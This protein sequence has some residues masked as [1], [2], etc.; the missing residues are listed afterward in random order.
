MKHNWIRYGWLVLALAACLCF[1]AVCAAEEVPAG[2]ADLVPDTPATAV[3]TGGQLTWFRFVPGET[4]NYS[5][6]SSTD[7][8]TFAYLYEKTGDVLHELKNDDDG[9]SRN[10]FQIVYELTAGKEYYFGVRFY[11]GDKSGSF[12]VTIEKYNGLVAAMVNES[13]NLTEEIGKTVTLGISASSGKG[14]VTFTWA[15]LNEDGMWVLAEGKTGPEITVSV[16]AGQTHYQCKVTDGISTQ[17][18][19]F[20]V[21]GKDALTASAKGGETS[22]RVTPGSSREMEVEASSESG[23]INYEWYKGWNDPDGYSHHEA[24]PGADSAS[25]TAE[26][27]SRDCY[28]CCEVRSTADSA[29]VYFYFYID[30][31]ISVEP[32][33]KSITVA[34][35]GSAEMSVTAETEYGPLSYQW[36]YYDDDHSAA[37]VEG[38]TGA[39]FTAQNIRHPGVYYCQVENAYGQSQ[40]AY[41]YISVEGDFDAYPESYEIYT[42]PGA[43]CVLRVTASCEDG[44]A[45]TFQWYG[46]VQDKRDAPRIIEGQTADTYVME[47]ASAAGYY[48]CRVKNTVGIEKNIWI[49]VSIENG[50]DA[51]STHDYVYGNAGEEAVLSADAYCY[52]GS[53]SY[54][55]YIGD[56]EKSGFEYARR[57]EGA[58]DETYSVTDPLKYLTVYYCLVT[59]TYG[60]TLTVIREAYFDGELYAESIGETSRNVK[61]GGSETFAVSASGDGIISYRW[62]ARTMQADGSWGDFQAIAGA[63]SATCTVENVRGRMEVRCCISTS[64]TNSTS[65]YFNVYVENDLRVITGGAVYV[66][67]N[68]TATLSVNASCTAGS[69][70]YQWYEQVRDAFNNSFDK[71]IAGATGSSYTTEPV[72]AH[73]RYVCRVT[74]DYGNSNNAYIDVYIDNG[75]DAERVGSYETSVKAGGTA[76]LQVTASVLD[77]AI[78]YQWSKGYYDDDEEW[79]ETEIAGAT[80]DTYTTE[81]VN[82]RTYYY[83][84]VSDDYENSCSVDFSVSVDNKLTARPAG[85]SELSVEPGKTAALEVLASVDAGEIHYQWYADYGDGQVFIEGATGAAFTTQAISRYSDFYCNVSDDYGNT[86]DVWFYVG[87]D[88]AFTA[89]AVGETRP[90][91]NPGESLTLEVSAGVRTG[92]IHYAWYVGTEHEDE[93]IEGANRAAFTTPAIDKATD[94]YCVVTD[95]FGNNKRVWFYVGIENELT[96]GAV[97]PREF[98]VTPGES[99][100]LEVSA[101]VKA[102]GIRYQWYKELRDDSGYWGN[103]VISGATEAVYETG[104]IDRAVNYYCNVEDDYGNIRSVMFY[105]GIDNEFSV[106]AV[107]PS[108]I[109]VAPGGGSTL[110][111]SAS[112]RTGEIHYQWYTEYTNPDGYPEQEKISGATG[113][114]YTFSGIDRYTAFYCLITD[115]YGNSSNLWFYV[116]IENG[117]TA[118]AV[119]KTSFSV[120]PGTTGLT[121]EVSAAA[122]T[123]E[124]HYQWLAEDENWDY[125]DIPGANAASYTIGEITRF[126]RFQCL[127]TDDYGNNRSVTFSIGINNELTVAAVGDTEMKVEPEETATLQVRASVKTGSI[128]YQ[129]YADYGYG[130]EPVEGATADTFTTAAITRYSSFS[131]RVS[132]DY[133][134]NRT[135]WFSVGIDN[136]F[137]ARP[138]GPEEVTTAPGGTAT[139][140]IIASVNHGGITYEWNKGTT[141][142]YGDLLWSRIPDATGAA[143]TTEAILEF[144]EYHC[145]VRDDYGNSRDIWFS[146]GVEN[147]LDAWAV[148]PEY[149]SVTPGTAVTLEVGATVGSGGLHYQWYGEY[150]TTEGYYEDYTIQGATEPTYAPGAVT[151]A[152]RYNCRVSDDYKNSVTVRFFVSLENH[153]LAE[154]AGDTNLTVAPEERATLQVYAEAD[155]GQIHYEWYERVYYAPGDY[156]TEEL[157]W[158]AAEAVYVTEPMSRSTNYTCYVS[159]DY[160]NRESV[161]FSVGIDNRLVVKPA[162]ETHLIVSKGD[163]VTMAIEASAASGTLKYSWQYEYRL[164]GNT[165]YFEGIPGAAEAS[166]TLENIQKS[167]VYFGQAE[168]QYGNTNSV[169]FEVEIENEL[170]AFS[171]QDYIQIVAPGSS[172]TLN[173][174]ATCTEGEI[175]YMWTRGDTVVSGADSGTL[176]MDNIQK[177][178]QIQCIVSDQYGNEETIPFLVVM[179]DFQTLVPGEEYS[180]PVDRESNVNVYSFVPAATGVYRIAALTRYQNVILYDADWK[181]VADKDGYEGRFSLE[182]VLTGG[183]RYYYVVSSTNSRNGSVSFL[184]EQTDGTQGVISLQAGQTVK[185]PENEAYGA[186][187]SAG[188]TSGNLLAVSGKTLTA[189]N[190][191]EGLLTVDYENTQI[192]YTVEVL[193]P[194]GGLVMPASLTTV[195]EEAYA[196]DPLVQFAELGAKVTLVEANAFAGS[197]LKQILITNS[198]TEL[199]EGAFGTVRPTILCPAGSKAETYARQHGYVWLNL[200]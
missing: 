135:V 117:L 66:A 97:G 172:L 13:M 163:D 1:T 28:Y 39:A 100:T 156:W 19:S 189:V 136:G 128:A 160:G 92:A 42:D 22:F 107:T 182:N 17:Y 71:K 94:F 146:V 46:P 20:M 177:D 32:Q 196:G 141:T 30:A 154:A 90:R 70:H 103:Q 131:C 51:S 105:I 167:G 197:G 45:L 86:R 41:F 88:N 108:D 2:A 7:M 75:L 127:V 15:T 12:P 58:T 161:Y 188:C 119:G 67:P 106:R 191:G 61:H 124:V 26:N 140:E 109:E 129:W 171:E 79:H 138:A 153:F 162:T 96:A 16:V 84:E 113:A 53:L 8:D 33:G 35:G 142:P 38:A 72:T 24:V 185:I 5:F 192:R 82:R 176:R 148:T 31:P 63:T 23:T 157:I 121:L 123:G 175:R 152:A 194:E 173:V 199:K 187:V 56:D 164:D 47:S 37:A 158:G 102:G 195:G 73:R 151:E 155:A 165:W 125:N 11:D 183:S 34:Y 145:F 21:S 143:Y 174:S 10:N 115:D 50:L 126:S 120:E 40:Y 62:E 159:D 27:I 190:T 74:D 83:C 112:V 166:Y 36:Y 122:N 9:G 184:F 80:G 44:D 132:D 114:A 144:A 29:S 101:H 198:A 6:Y 168:D 77:G 3:V 134:N 57:I 87:I 147:G 43:A 85:K 178:Y 76:T 68:E 52:E 139:L 89:E 118:Q 110:E 200:P 137:T 98:D 91:V 93:L 193:T 59:D 54:Q 81:P 104:A 186:F 181:Y 69:L 99:A 25:F 150:L 18:F 180:S 111:V 170:T 14:E 64:F 49:R 78:H 149:L 65:V 55:W 169:R 4:A 179:S 48:L 60:N 116:G 130:R 95:D 133:G